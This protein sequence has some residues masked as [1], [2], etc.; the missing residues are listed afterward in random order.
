MPNGCGILIRRGAYVSTG[1]VLVAGATVGEDAVVGAGA[2]V[3]SD[4]PP[5]VL[6]MGVPARVVRSLDGSFD[7][8]R[9]ISGVAGG[10]TRSRSLEQELPR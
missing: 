4:V 1:A 10:R 2:V 7:Y 3:T 6:V 8:S 5:R 9:L